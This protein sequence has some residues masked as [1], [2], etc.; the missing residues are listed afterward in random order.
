MRTFKLLSVCS[1]LLGCVLLPSL[2]AAQ[3]LTIGSAEVRRGSTVDIPVQFVPG[4]VDVVAFQVAVVYDPALLDEP[5]CLPSVAW[6]CGVNHDIGRV[7][8]VHV[9]P[10]LQPLTEQTYAE[11]RFPVPRSAGRGR[12]A[13]LG[14]HAVVMSDVDSGSAPFTVYTGRID[15]R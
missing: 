12:H 1:F 8:I 13:L 15:V 7:V 11:I 6:F 2:A 3:T 9:T 14:A 4:D 10:L 5:V